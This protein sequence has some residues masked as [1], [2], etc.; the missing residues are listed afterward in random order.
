M[1]VSAQNPSQQIIAAGGQT[2]FPFNFRCDDS[3]TLTAWVG[4]AQQGGFGI[5]L[6]PDQIGA[7][8]GNVTLPAQAAGAV[9]TIERLTPQAQNFLLTAYTAF[10]A[11]AVTA[12]MDKL[13]ELLQ[14]FWSKLSRAPVVKRANVPNMDNFDLPAPV[15]GSAIGWGLAASGKFQLVNMGAGGAG[16]GGDQ[17]VVNERLVDSGDHVNF[18]VAHK[19]KT[20]AVYRTGQRVFNP[21]DYVLNAVQPYVTLVVALNAAAG[22]RLDADYTW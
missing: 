9:V 10:T 19:P 21:D 11:V 17:V 3:T 15:N 14:E 16:P 5:A 20:I 8:G 13:M 6:N 1:P 2:V 4:D 7:P 18:T 12:A 22:E